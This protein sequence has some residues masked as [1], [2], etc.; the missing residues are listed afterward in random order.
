MRQRHFGEVLRL[1]IEQIQVED[2]ADVSAA[3]PPAVM[4]IHDTHLL[5]D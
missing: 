4:E 2:F 1:V 3:F 5:S